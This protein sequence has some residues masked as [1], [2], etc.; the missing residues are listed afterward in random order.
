MYSKFSSHHLYQV[1]I[2]HFMEI[3]NE[4]S[5][6]TTVL[7]QSIEDLPTTVAVVSLERGGCRCPAVPAVVVIVVV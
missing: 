3:M 1:S 2:T 7:D 5:A 6:L 4:C